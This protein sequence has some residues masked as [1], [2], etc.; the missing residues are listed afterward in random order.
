MRTPPFRRRF[1]L[2]AA[3]AASVAAPF[4]LHAQPLPAA[5]PASLGFDAQRLSRI[6]EVF[7][8]EVDAGRIPGAV[9]MVARKG[10]LAYATELG[11]LDKASATPM[12][13]DGVFRIYSMT[14]PFASVAAMM[15]VEEG[16][17]HLTDPVGRFI[18]GFA[19]QV[20][21]P[22]LHPV[23]AAVSYALVPASRQPQVLDLLRH[24]SGLAYG[25]LTSN[26]RVLDAYRASGLFRAS[27][28]YDTRQLSVADYNK[29]VA[30]A[31]LA[32]QPGTVWE[33]S[34][35]T[36]VLGRVVEAASGQ[37]LEAFLEDRLFR[38]LRMNDTG[39]AL[40]DGQG[41]RLAKHLGVDP[42]NNQSIGMIDV[43]A[44]PGNA[45]GGAGAIS[46]AGDYL[47][48]GQMLLNGGSLDGVRVLSPT[49][50]RLMASDHLAGVAQPEP[51][52]VLGTAGYSF[53]LGFAVRLADGNAGIPGSAGEFMWAG[54][55]GTFFWVDPK[56]ELVGVFM[57]AAPSVNRAVHR[58]L[59]KQLVYAAIAE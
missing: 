34:I 18:P 13:R 9:V 19:P 32:K 8:A 16:R 20:A 21:E 55:G 17:L 11:F 37:R 47:R 58:R 26:A 15:L 31:P 45:S 3:L 29:A 44:A 51:P 7:K 1:L 5:D 59:V 24:T 48:F 23:T 10:R 41:G 14:K 4:G 30:A 36:D 46:T 50:V 53:G 33:Y 54:Y 40:R 49:T 35:S 27:D 25:E 2:V 39:F 28:P 56:Q 38:P 42:A 12:S 43:S 57:S 52:G 22:R 6:G